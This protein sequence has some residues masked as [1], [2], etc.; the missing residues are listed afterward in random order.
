MSTSTPIFFEICRKKSEKD[1][2]KIKL[3]EL[4]EQENQLEDKLKLLQCE[5]EKENKDVERLEKV[6]LSTIIYTIINK[7]VEKIGKEKE[8][9]YLA[10]L[11]YD[12]AVVELEHVR[13][14]IK[15]CIAGLNSFNDI[16]KEYQAAYNERLIEL[17]KSDSIYSA[18]ILALE[19]E[20][21]DADHRKKESEE[22]KNVAERALS[23]AYDIENELESAKSWSTYDTFFGGGMFAD[24]SKH[25]HLDNAQDLVGTLQNQLSALKAELKDVNIDSNIYVRIDGFARFAD[26]FFDNFFT[27][28][29]VNDSINSSL[30]HIESIKHELEATIKKLDEI[31]KNSVKSSD[32][33]RTRIETIVAFTE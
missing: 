29:S 33:K 30:S 10:G 28:L 9:A 7:K 1:G 27:D 21:A 31:Y 25:E 17:K 16:D 6:T 2:L 12:A 15:D 20:I 4:K 14:K 3:S 24:L 13:D 23:V 19:A 32:S 8:E 18:E 22:A 5:L 11:K 26:Y